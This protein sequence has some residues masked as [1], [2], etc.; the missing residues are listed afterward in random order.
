MQKQIKYFLRLIVAAFLFWMICSSTH[1]ATYVWPG[2]PPCNANLQDC[3]DNIGSGDTIEIAINTV[4]ESLTIGKSLTLKPASGYSPRLGN[5]ITANTIIANSTGTTN[6]AVTIEGLTIAFGIIT[7]THESSGTFTLNLVD[8]TIEKSF[9]YAAPIRF[10]PINGG[11]TY[12]N[13]SSNNMTVPIDSS[14]HGIQLHTNSNIEG[15]IK[16]NMIVMEGT[17]QGSAIEVTNLSSASA[18]V[19]I[20]GNKIDGTNMN[21][22]ILIYQYTSGCHTNTTIA[23]NLITGQAGNTGGPGALTFY[24]TDGT[25]NLQ[26][27][28]N[29]VV[30]NEK[31]IALY[32]DTG[33]TTGKIANNIIANNT[34]SGLY[35]DSNVASAV[36][37]NHNLVYNNGSNDFTAGTGTLYVDPFF[38]GVDDYR[39]QPGSAAINNGDNASVPS[40]ITT[41]IRGNPRIFRSVVDIGAYERGGCITTVLPLLLF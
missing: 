32:C 34:L 23:N 36:S 19:E 22:G 4:N 29:T 39:L 21:N 6:N 18:A 25:V 37:N 16:N 20:L 28:N 11:M 41:D 26:V 30:D 8:N 2:A 1:A 5:G 9:T 7:I 17:T 10:W 33:T 35:I 15:S 12:F 14:A 24:V 13:I 38:I 40:G 3:I 31:G 27:I